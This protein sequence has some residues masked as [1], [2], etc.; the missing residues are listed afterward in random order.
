M[1]SQGLV[2]SARPRRYPGQVRLT[3]R[4]VWYADDAGQ[5]PVETPV[6]QPPADPTPPPPAPTND[7]PDVPEW[8]KDPAK[9]YAE[10]QKLRGG[11]AEARQTKKRLAELEAQAKTAE[12]QRLADQ[13]KWQELAEKRERELAQVRE[14]AKAAELTALR[15]RIST[16]L[17]LPPALAE[18]LKGETEDD[19]RADAEALKALLP[20]PVQQQP[21]APGA[22][23][24]T[25]AVPGGPPARETDDQRRARL[26]GASTTM[27][28][29]SKGGVV[30]PE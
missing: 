19:L 9:A 26:F 12:D 16:E 8:V 25:S 1:N 2:L 22:R 13:Q 3:A 7:A 21:P 6:G 23:P 10:I 4:R 17:G 29:R 28:D 15:L 27:F 18:R 5:P 11:E 24:T 30:L 20:A 14:Q